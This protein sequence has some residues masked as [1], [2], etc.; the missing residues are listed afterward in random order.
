MATPMTMMASSFVAVV[1]YGQ[2]G[3]YSIDSSQEHQYGFWH[4]FDPIGRLGSS[5]S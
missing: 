5:V 2:G 1:R 4:V 3:T